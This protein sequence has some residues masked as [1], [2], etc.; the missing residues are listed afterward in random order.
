MEIRFKSKKL[1]RCYRE[2]RLAIREWGHE[3]GEKYIQRINLMKAAK[4]VD[5]LMEM[6]VLGCH[7]L[8]GDRQGHYAMKLTASSD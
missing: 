4:A 1:E 2:S 6:R 8:K 3:V 7:P 5:E